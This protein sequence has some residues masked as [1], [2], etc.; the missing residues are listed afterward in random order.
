MPD[1]VWSLRFTP[2]DQ[3]KRVAVGLRSLMSEPH[4]VGGQG[5]HD[6]IYDPIARWLFAQVLREPPR[7]TADRLNR[8]RW[9]LKGDTFDGFPELDGIL[10]LQ[11]A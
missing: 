5:V 7:L 3:L 4:E 6:S 9:F 10:A 1:G 11:R 2:V 8:Q